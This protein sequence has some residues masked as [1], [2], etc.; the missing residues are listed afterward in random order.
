MSAQ[1]TETTDQDITELFMM[2]DKDGDN[3]IEQAELKTLLRVVYKTNPDERMVEEQLHKF[4]TD[5]S[6]TIDLE[7]FKQLYHSMPYK[8]KGR[9]LRHMFD[10]YDANGDGDLSIEEVKQF[11]GSLGAKCSDKLVKKL[12][13]EVDV[14]DDG[15]VD[16]REFCLMFGK[17]LSEH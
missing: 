12:M 11:L 8:P 13:K 5:R 3:K 4:D 2:F 1:V 6:G 17:S 10:E 9:K 15:R 14:N 16:F 7:E